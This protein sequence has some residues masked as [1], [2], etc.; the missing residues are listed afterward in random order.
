MG[1]PTGVGPEILLKAISSPEFF[2]KARYRI[3]GDAYFLKKVKDRLKIKADLSR[4]EI[5]DFAWE[6]LKNI[7][8]QGII[9][10]VD[11]QLHIFVRAGRL[12]CLNF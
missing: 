8:K 10:L 7:F 4:L 6:L 3:F 9:C 12:R 11:M 1:D 5:I 2:N